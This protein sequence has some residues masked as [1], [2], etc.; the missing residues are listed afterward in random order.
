[1]PR[2]GLL[3]ASQTQALHGL[4]RRGPYPL[5]RTLSRSSSLQTPS[6]DARFRN[7]PPQI[8]YSLVYTRHFTTSER[9]TSLG[10]QVRRLPKIKILIACIALSPLLTYVYEKLKDRPVFDIIADSTIFRVIGPKL[11]EPPDSAGE[12]IYKPITREKEIRLLVL[13]PG[14]PADELKCR[15][16]HAELSWKT[17]YEAL[18]YVWGDGAVTRPLNCSGHTEAI[19]INLYDALSDLRLPDRE[20]ILWTDRLCINQSDDEE[21]ATQMQRMGEIYSHASQVLIYLGKSDPSVE[22]A[23]ET[24]RRADSEFMSLLSV[25]PLLTFYSLWCLVTK[26]EIKWDPLINLLR[27]P[28]FQRT[29]VFQEAV[30]AKRGEVIC[31]DQSVPWSVF[32]RSIETLTAYHCALKEIPAYESMGTIMSCISLMTTARS[33]RRTEGQTFLPRLWLYRQPQLPQASLKLLD[34][35]LESRS[36]KVTN[37]KDK[38]FGMLDVTSQD[39]RSDYLKR[40]PSLSVGDAFRNFV[41]WDIF[42]NNSL[43]ALGSS[44][45][46]AGSGYSS[47]SWVPDFERLDPHSSLTGNKNLVKFNASTSL[48][49]QVWAS[50]DKNVLYIKGKI[51]DTLHTV[52]KGLP[53]TPRTSASENA[54]VYHFEPMDHLL[55]NKHM[56]EEA[57]DIW[58]A[59]TKRLAD[60]RDPFIVAGVKKGILATARED[61]KL[62]WAPFLRTLVCNRTEEGKTAHKDFILEDVASFVRQTLEVG[63]VPEYLLQN[64]RPRGISGL[65]AFNRL[66]ESRRFAATDMGL[67]GYVPLRAKKGDLVCILYGSEVP[68]VIRKEAGGKCSLVGECYMHGIMEGEAL[69]AGANG[70]EEEVFTLT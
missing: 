62:S 63:V 60:C 34:L 59:A 46:K 57:K 43:R 13:E 39:I 32:E 5:L 40:D 48:P 28:W 6:I 7:I 17:R 10:T 31:G 12:A 50:D 69:N 18:S 29:W 58:L 30:L 47:P 26:D 52:G 41:L 9:F 33:V 37:S 53:A 11:V 1:M 16:I 45:D 14:A 27:R 25:N 2:R 70:H 64:D 8:T 23:M 3:L 54:H 42:E 56:I 68:F 35:V 44:S 15:I 24:I 65:R 38:V 49:K 21:I 19:Y 20:R 66:T 22:G 4:G 67:V 51:I 55:I 61:G 36:F